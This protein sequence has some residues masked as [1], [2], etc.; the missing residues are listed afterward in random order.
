MEEIFKKLEWD[1]MGLKI[2]G[3]Y[4]NNLRFADDIVLLTNSGEDLEKMISDLHRNSLKVGLKMNMKKTKIMYNK[5]LLGGQ[6]M[7]GSK[8]LELVEEYACLRQIV[9]GNPSHEKDIRR[10]GMGWS[11]FDK[12][13]LLMNSNFPLF[14]KRKVYN[15]RILPVLTYRSK[16]WRLTK[17]LKRKL[18]SAQKLMGRRVVGIT[19]RDKKRAS[20]IRK[21]TKIEEILMTIKN[22]KWTCP[23]HVMRRRDNRWTTKVT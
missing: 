22:K 9:G 23:G 2:D 7:T 17:E 19:W 4:L 13:N 16:T 21:Q 8:A 5:H 18:R 20:C 12:Q 3:E 14:L 10:I 6:I 1:D 15:H 11:A